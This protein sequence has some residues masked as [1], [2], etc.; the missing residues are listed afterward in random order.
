MAEWS[1]ALLGE[2]ERM[3]TSLRFPAGNPV[4]LLEQRRLLSAA[5]HAALI[6]EIRKLEH[7]KMSDPIVLDL[8]TPQRS[9]AQSNGPATTPFGGD[10]SPPGGLSPLQMQ[11]AY[12]VGSINF[13][14]IVGD[15]TGQTIAIIDAYDD[16]GLVN[17]TS[18]SF[19]TSDLAEFD[20]Y[21]GLANPPS[22]TKY[23]VNYST[24][25]VSATLPGTDPMGPYQMTGS[26]GWE[27]EESLDVEWAHVMAPNAN[28][29][30]I[31]ADNS[32]DLYDAI[33]AADNLSGVGVVSMSFDG[34]ESQ[35]A[36]NSEHLSGAAEEAAIDSTY[37]SNA[38]ITYVAASGDSGAY[39]RGSEDTTIEPQFPAT[40]PDVLAVGGTTLAVTGNNTWSSETV[41]GN[42]SGSGTTYGYPGGGGGGGGISLYETKPVYQA[43]VTLATDRMYPDLSLEANNSPGVPVF[44]SF[45]DGSGTPWVPG[46]V[47]G[48]S[49]SAPMM[50]GLVAIADQ[51]RALVG[52][53]ALNSNSGNYLDIHNLIY[54]LAGNPTAYADDFHD[55]TSGSNG[56][57]AAAGFDLAS[58]LGSPIANNLVFDLAAIS[59]TPAV[60]QPAISNLYYKED[61]DGTQI[62]VWVNS[63][64]PGDGAPTAKFTISDA[65]AFLYAAAVGN[66]TL[67]LDFSAGDFTSAFS[68]MTYVGSASGSNAI[69]YVG[70]TGNDAL[71]ATV[72]EISPGGGWG[73]TPIAIANVQN[74]QLLGGS[75]GSD[76]LTVLSS[77]AEGFNVNADTATG[78]PNVSVNVA[79]TGTLVNFNTSQHLAALSILSGDSAELTPGANPASKTLVVGSL[80]IG[81]TG[82][83][84]LSDNFMIV[85]NG[86]LGGISA[87]LAS[88]YSGGAWNGIGIFS[89]TAQNDSTRRTALGVLLNNSAG[90]PIY[91]TFDGQPASLN[92]V[93]LKYTYYGDAN[94][95]G[96][97]DSSDL[98][99]LDN[100]FNGDLTGWQN[101]EFDYSGSLNGSDYTILDNS[102]NNPGPPL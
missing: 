69:D 63:T 42:G 17:S 4:E 74:I 89:S 3:G 61:A 46:S 32:T 82:R 40:S 93:I 92:D 66:N 53:L 72:A 62:D 67:T 26:F 51:G 101:G 60:N 99:R 36:N 8:S 91:T 81:G 86:S 102:F 6:A 27:L 16:P 65:S 7:P 96:V 88:G 97:V 45:D 35:L 70:T 98:T 38:A 52:H 87:L 22:F 5:Y 58:G 15:G 68:S 14:G 29:V 85:H 9:A 44:D 10:N 48:T 11:G 71:T 73:S 84:D 37:F 28:I 83:L 79:G 90:L 2:V 59:T 57:N 24:M 64:S 75:G 55:I 95:D 18:T 94:L 78:T 12:G 23:G 49:L 1:R 56:Y 34:D 31:E 19:A 21:F 100:G 43:T 39:G 33:Y 47:G 54:N 80:S 20:A 77:P 50:A 76:S 13:D 25:T 41:W 30:L